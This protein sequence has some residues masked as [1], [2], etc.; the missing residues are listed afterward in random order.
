MPEAVCDSHKSGFERNALGRLL[1][2]TFIYFCKATK[3]TGHLMGEV[4]LSGN[5]FPT[6][7]PRVSITLITY[8]EL[9]LISFIFTRANSTLRDTPRGSPARNHCPVDCDQY[10]REG[11]GF[12]AI[13]ETAR[14]YST[15][16]RGSLVRQANVSPAC[17][18]TPRR[19]ARCHF[20][21]RLSTT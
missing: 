11:R 8:F 6:A 3:M 13:E 15:P 14:V 7:R 2:L 12:R 20:V 10:S 19:R 17:S 9:I 5:L 1:T 4:R 16:R 21:D 18:R